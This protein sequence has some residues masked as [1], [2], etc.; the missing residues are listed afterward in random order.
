MGPGNG[1]G[2]IRRA[3]ISWGAMARGVLMAKWTNAAYLPLAED[4]I[5]AVTAPLVP[6]G[7]EDNAPSQSNGNG[8]HEQ[9]ELFA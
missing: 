9:V 3:G 7:Y 4:R 8:A 1:K 2:A 5:A 6:A